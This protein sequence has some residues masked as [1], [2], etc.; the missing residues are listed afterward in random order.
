[1]WEKWPLERPKYIPLQQLQ[2]GTKNGGADTLLTVIIIF[3]SR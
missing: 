3:H 2:S 1:M